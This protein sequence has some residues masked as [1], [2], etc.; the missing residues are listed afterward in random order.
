MIHEAQENGQIT[1]EYVP[2]TYQIANIF[3][4]PLTKEKFTYMPGLI[5]L[6]GKIPQDAG[7]EA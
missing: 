5:G 1:T 7:L 2:T 3:T 4:K 6:P